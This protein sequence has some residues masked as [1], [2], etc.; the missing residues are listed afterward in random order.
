MDKHASLGVRTKVAGFDWDEGNR[1]KY[2]KHGVSVSEIE[3]LFARPLMILPDPAHS[4]REERLRAIGRTETGRYVFLVF[5]V[6]KRGGADYIRPINAR[7]MHRKEIDHY[8]AQNPQLRERRG[9]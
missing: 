8:E 4:E 6:R 5:T 1:R 9:S 2:A 7:Y 3:H